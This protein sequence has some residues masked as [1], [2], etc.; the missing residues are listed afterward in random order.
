MACEL[1]GCGD[2][3]IKTC[4][5]PEGSRLLVCDPCF[6]E[7]VTELVIVPGER[8]VTARCDSCGSYGNPRGF[9]GLRL[10]GQKGGYSGTCG[11]CAVKA[12]PG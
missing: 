3:W 2:A 4:L 1:C 8:L 12:S 10:G 9:S 11:A 6:A 5:I 7:H